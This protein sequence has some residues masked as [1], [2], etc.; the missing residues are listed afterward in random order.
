MAGFPASRLKRLFEKLD[1]S[2]QVSK[3]LCDMVVFAPQNLL[4]DPR[5]S[6]LDLVSYSNVLVY[7][8][9]KRSGGLSPSVSS[10]SDWRTSVSRQCEGDRT[11]RRSVRNGVEEMAEIPKARADWHDLIYHPPPR[12]R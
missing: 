10:H 3:E 5:L 9:R 4:R 2:Y 1:G 8:E 6:Q 11:T 12:A 7:L